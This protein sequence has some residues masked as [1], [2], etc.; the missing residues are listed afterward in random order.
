[1]MPPL[2]QQSGAGGGSGGG[3]GGGG[4]G[5]SSGGDSKGGSVATIAGPGKVAGSP[6]TTRPKEAAPVFVST[7]K[8]E[9]SKE[10]SSG[11]SMLPDSIV[12][13]VIPKIE[14]KPKAS[15]VTERKVASTGGE[16]LEGPQAQVPSAVAT[17]A[18][19]PSAESAK[20]F[21]N[22]F[23]TSEARSGHGLTR[24]SE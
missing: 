23:D 22:S 11:A 20:A 8:K 17:N 3:S 14:E 2:Q 1:M 16:T 15:E 19:A 12:A 4:S 13:A 6:E 5:S 10:A 9:K 24:D 18:S 7:R 21:A